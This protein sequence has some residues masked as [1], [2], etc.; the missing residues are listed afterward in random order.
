MAFSQYAGRGQLCALFFKLLFL[1]TAFL[2]ILASR[3]YVQKFEPFPG[4]ILRFNTAVNLGMMLMAAT[5]DL[6][7]IYIA[8]E[9]DQHLIV[10]IW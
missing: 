9:L 6:I 4:R 8:L 1:G 2:V 5:N 10:C 3:D 7:S